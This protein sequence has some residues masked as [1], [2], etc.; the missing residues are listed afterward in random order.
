MLRIF[1][2][3]SVTR[4]GEI[5]PLWQSFERL[6][7]FLECLLSF[8]QNVVPTLAIFDATQQILIVTNGQ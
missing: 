6:W 3:C 7:H 5:L 4:F 2:A 8:W 1:A